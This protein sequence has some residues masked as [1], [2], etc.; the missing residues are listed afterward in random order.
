MN[1]DLH[2]IYRFTLYN[3]FKFIMRFLKRRD[4]I[5]DKRKILS[6]IKM[7]PGRDKMTMTKHFSIYMYVWVIDTN[8]NACLSRSNRTSYI[9]F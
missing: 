9:V 3:V 2:S 8:K 5:K 4:K 7:T 6:L 1:L